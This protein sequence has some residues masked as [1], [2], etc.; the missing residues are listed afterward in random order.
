[1][2]ASLIASAVSSSRI[3]EASRRGREVALVED[4]VDDGEHAVHAL[5]E[6][7]R[8][9]DPVGDLGRADLLLRA[10]DALRHRRLGDEEGLR[11]LGHG[12]AAEQAQG[13]RHPRLG[14][15]RGVAAGED[16]PQPVVLDHAGRLVGCVVGHHECRLVL[17][18]AVG[19][20]ADP[21]DRAVARGRGQ[22]AAGVGRYAVAGPA[23]D[24]GQ[25]RLAGRLLG[26]V[27]VAEA[28]G[29]RGDDPAVLLAVDPLDRGRGVR[30]AIGMSQVRAG[31][32]RAS[33]PRRSGRLGLEGT[34]LDLALRRPSTPRSPTPGR[35]RGRAARG[36]RSRRSTPWTRRTGRR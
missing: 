17:G 32:V 8:R 34:D 28:A 35:R 4:Q 16:Q 18:V 30:R 9:R 14:C 2:R 25:Q 36:S 26:D 5:A 22:P 6:V 24:G 15:E 11:D 29:Q 33:P 12:E 7:L 21:V 31:Q 13:Q 1:M 23:L 27:D 3:G 19:L 10:G 20:A